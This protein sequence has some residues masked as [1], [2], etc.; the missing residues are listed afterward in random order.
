MAVRV[1]KSKGVAKVLTKNQMILD[2]GQKNFGPIKCLE[3]SMIYVAGDAEDLKSHQ[4]YHADFLNQEIKVINLLNFQ[5]FEF[6]FLCV[7]YFFF[8]WVVVS[9]MSNFRCLE[10]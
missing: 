10:D 3:C 2:F 1:K 8:E 7:K 6:L 9:V 4:R 5:D